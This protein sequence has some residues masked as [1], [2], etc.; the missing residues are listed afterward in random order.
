MKRLFLLL[1]LPLLLG[2][3]LYDNPPSTPSKN[4]DTWLV[5]QWE[6]VDKAG[7]TYQAVVAPVLPDHYRITVTQSGKPPET[8][9]GWLSE[10]G[11]FIILVVKFTDGP[12]A[13]KYALFH[14]ELL[15]PASPPPGDV[16]A[17]RIRLS[18]LQLD[19]SAENMDSYHLRQVIRKALKDGT[20]LPA[21]DVA[22]E[23]KEE[24]KEAEAISTLTGDT[25]LAKPELHRVTNSTSASTSTNAT[26]LAPEKLVLP[27][28][29]I[30]IKT[31]SITLKGD[32][33]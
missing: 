6:A 1:T 5:G 18:E 22:A 17:T 30:W 10:L 20:L 4:I 21:Y 12:N 8:F 2:G 19:P 14:H 33:F 3:C 25:T 24:F 13:G 31:G 9:D 32:T 29:V 16:G 26:T 28:S 7:H 15:T 23:R 11:N 27:G